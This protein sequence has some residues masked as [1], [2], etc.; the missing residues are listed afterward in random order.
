MC[1]IALNCGSLEFAHYESIPNPNQ[2]G[3]RINPEPAFVPNLHSAHKPFPN[4][5]FRPQPPL[6]IQKYKLLSH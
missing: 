3:V 6:R 5:Q 2:P 1:L 4:Q